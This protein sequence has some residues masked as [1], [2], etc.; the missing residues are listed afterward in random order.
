MAQVKDRGKDV[1]VAKESESSE[2]SSRFLNIGSTLVFKNGSSTV[3]RDVPFSAWLSGF[4]EVIPI[5]VSLS[6]KKITETQL[7]A[8]LA[9]D[10]TF[11]TALFS[12][13]SSA[14]DLTPT[15]ISQLSLEDSLR[16]LATLKKVI[17]F[18]EVKKLFSEV[19]LQMTTLST[20]KKSA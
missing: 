9:T 19:G 13:M 2:D 17:D 10:K 14:T 8:K 16:L 3:V 1:K 11:Q 7:L 20:A 4:S 6:E 15:E 5:L 18:V 12:L